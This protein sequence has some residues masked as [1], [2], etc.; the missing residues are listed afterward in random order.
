MNIE[1][2]RLYIRPFIMD[3]VYD[4]HELFVQTEVMQSVGLAPAFTTIEESSDRIAKWITYGTHFAIVLKETSIVI[5]YVAIKPDSEEGCKDT[6]ELGFALNHKYQHQGFMTE[7]IKSVIEYL[8]VKGITFVWACC[9]KE[10][11]ESK[12]LIER[13]GFE[14]QNSAEHFVETEKRSYQSLEYRINIQKT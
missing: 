3:D 5:G 6:R 7:T 13:L 9:F 14:F 2:E 12:N 1:T 8:E 10:N 4:M 11:V